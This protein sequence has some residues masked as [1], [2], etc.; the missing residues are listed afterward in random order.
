MINLGVMGENIS[1]LLDK[2]QVAYK[3]VV[4]FRVWVN[5]LIS[6]TLALLFGISLINFVCTKV[7]GVNEDNGEVEKRGECGSA[8]ITW[9]LIYCW[10]WVI[11]NET[12]W[13]VLGSLLNH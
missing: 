3:S 13:R 5:L 11:M 8:N 9:H 4:P 6:T 2:L 1:K 10:F 12:P 7:N